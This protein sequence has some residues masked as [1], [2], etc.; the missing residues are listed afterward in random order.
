M[1]DKKTTTTITVSM[2]I[3]VA[4]SVRQAAGRG[5]VSE[6]ITEAT[7]FRLHMQGLQDIADDIAE[8][9]GGPYTEDER[10]AVDR[11]WADALDDL[12]AAA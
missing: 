10:A 1:T 12:A 5:G 8:H 9:T 4:E 11:Q 7:R 6:F 2:P 3:D